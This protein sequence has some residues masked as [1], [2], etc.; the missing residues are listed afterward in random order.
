ML[1]LLFGILCLANLA[2]FLL[3][4]RLPEPEADTTPEPN[5]PRVEP[6]EV[7]EEREGVAKPPQ[8]P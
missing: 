7:L 2:I 5:L 1:R 6:I 4:A 3:S 8:N